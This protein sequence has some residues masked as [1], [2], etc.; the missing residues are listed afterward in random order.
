MRIAMVSPYALTRPG[1][2]QGQVLGLSRSLHRLGHDVTVIGPADRDRLSPM[3]RPFSETGER[4]VI[5]I[6]H[7]TGVRSNGSVAPVALSPMAARRAERAVHAGRFDV[8]H[9]HEP[10]AP[11]A[12]YGL[13]LQSRVPMVGTYHRAG[14][15]RWVPVLKPLASLVGRRLQVRVAVSEAARQTGERS[16]GGTFE[17]LFNGVEV[18]RFASAQSERTPGGVPIMLFV[19]RHEERKGL[20]VLLE[21]FAS[22][23]RP[24]VLCIAGGGPATGALRALHPQTD[25]VRWLGVLDDDELARQL[26]GADVLCAPSLHGESFG[27]VLLEGMAA[28][29]AVVASDIEGYRAAAGGLAILVAPGDVDALNHALET[30]LADAVQGRGASSPEARQA[31]QEHARAWSMDALARRYLDVY[32]RAIDARSG[33]KR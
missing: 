13:V 3:A 4:D 7:P 15:S 14:V 16:G 18:E 20:A 5:V 17:V 19:G 12:S 27:V 24:A 33:T 21:A 28:G 30:A 6:G 31:A 26:A 25:R 9:L 8:V 11:V 32:E 29:C 1:G 22:L 2:V 10:L 23:D